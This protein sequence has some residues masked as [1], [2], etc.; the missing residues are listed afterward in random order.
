MPISKANKTEVWL[1]RLSTQA[2]EHPLIEGWE[3]ATFNHDL[4]TALLAYNPSASSSSWIERFVSTKIHTYC[5]I[6]PKVEPASGPDEVKHDGKCGFCGNT[7]SLRCTG[8][9]DTP[10]TNARFYCDPNCQKKD[11]LVHKTDC[12]RH[13]ERKQV[14][15]AASIL[16]SL[17][18]ELRTRC[19]DKAVRDVVEKHGVLHI[20]SEEYYF[21]RRGLFF[22]QPV[23]FPK[24]VKDNNK[25]AVLF[26]MQCDQLL[27]HVPELIQRIFKSRRSTTTVSS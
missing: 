14:H 18:Y 6:G 8:C 21:E 3:G 10:Y 19:F 17:L 9:I 11:W 12:I 24:S 23:S 7:A 4:T 13:K 1:Q 27:R 15:N 22:Y 5:G 25:E 2:I 20:D 26:M 16:K